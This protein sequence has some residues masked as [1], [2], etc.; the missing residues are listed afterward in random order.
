MYKV[1]FLPTF[2]LSV[3]F[4]DQILTKFS[5]NMYFKSKYTSERLFCK[6]FK[7]TFILPKFSKMDHLKFLQ[8]NGL[9][10]T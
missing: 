4:N 8:T 1:P 2:S 7:S 6:N 10:D 5:Q 9:D 3:E